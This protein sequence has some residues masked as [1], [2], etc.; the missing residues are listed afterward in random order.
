MV[1]VDFSSPRAC[2]IQVNCLLGAY[3]LSSGTAWFDDVSLVALGET[4]RGQRA[5]SLLP[6]G[7]FEQPSVCPSHWMMRPWSTESIPEFSCSDMIA[8]SGLN[9][10]CIKGKTPCDA[11]WTTVADVQPRTRYRLSAWIR[12]EN[13]TAGSG[14]GAFVNV[15]GR[16]DRCATRP[17]VGTSDWTHVSWDFSTR[18]RE[19]RVQIACS[20]GGWGQSSGTAWFDDVK[21]EALGRKRSGTR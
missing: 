3:G 9:S 12:T 4:G 19:N 13:V 20:L 14:V 8:R 16:R 1:D 17:L 6:H 2:R 18:S 5:W 7:G 15:H 21:L 11:G 10:V